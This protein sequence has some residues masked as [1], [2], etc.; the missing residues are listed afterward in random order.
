MPLK[1]RPCAICRV[2]FVPDARVGDRQ[3]ACSKP[4]CQKTRRCRTQAGWRG[5]HPDYFVALRLQQ[6][7]AASAAASAVPA[8]TTTAAPPPPGARPPPLDPLVMP[9]PL[10]R[11]PWDLA[12][13]QFG[14][15]GADF[16]SVFGRVL[17]GAAQSQWREQVAV[18]TR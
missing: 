13:D 15:Q 17:L 18:N 11:L 5:A 8:T 6:R 1:S 14:A 10:D 9:P 7:A 2:W 3:Y 16:L 4:Q 12:Q